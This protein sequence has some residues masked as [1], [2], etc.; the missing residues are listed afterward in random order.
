MIIY[1]YIY[2]Y[3]YYTYY[4]Y[5][6]LY[7]TKLNRA[8][9]ALI[10]ENCSRHFSCGPRQAIPTTVS[11][12]TPWGALQRSSWDNYFWNF[13]RVSEKV[14]DDSCKSCFGIVYLRKVG[15]LSSLFQRTTWHVGKP[16]G[17]WVFFFK[18]KD[19]ISQDIA[20]LILLQREGRLVES[21]LENI[22]NSL[23][24]TCFILGEK[25]CS[26]KL[27]TLMYKGGLKSKFRFIITFLFFIVHT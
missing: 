19:K 8:Y 5:I 24:R 15:L 25:K 7:L 20:I 21:S 3:I 22:L 27:R 9:I 10:H 23:V 4:N 6:H 11:F 16:Y 13:H 1:I 18:M 12:S 14:N 2:I 26:Q 17:H